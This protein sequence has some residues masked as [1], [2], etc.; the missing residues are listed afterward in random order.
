[1]RSWRSA[2]SSSGAEDVRLGDMPC[3][4]FVALSDPWAHAH[5][6]TDCGGD[7][8]A[9][10]HYSGAFEPYTDRNCLDSENI[11]D[12]ETGEAFNLSQSFFA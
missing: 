7:F 1:M 11:Y 2:V 4:A 3:A 10:G 5:F 9:G 6:V 12:P 8:R